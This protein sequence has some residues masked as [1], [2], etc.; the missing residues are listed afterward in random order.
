MRMRTPFLAGALCLAYAVPAGACTYAP[1]ATYLTVPATMTY[2]IGISSIFSDPMANGITGDLS[3][4]LGEK[5][6]VRP[7][8]GLCSVD[9]ETDPVFG[10]AFGL[11]L[12]Q[13][14]SMTLNLQSGISYLSFDGGS[15]MMIPIGAAARFTGSGSMNFYAGGSLVWASIDVD[16]FGSASDTN[17]MLYGGVM[18]RSGSMGWTLGGQL[19][20]GDDTEFGIVAGLNF[21]GA[22]SAL[23]NFANSIR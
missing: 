22:A 13:S 21:G 15:E 6:V 20:M 1:F 10:A 17:P 18:S 2:G 12:S 11:Q 14:S 5:A 4:K 3:M 19:L 9:S 16:G 8:V 23:R 7:M